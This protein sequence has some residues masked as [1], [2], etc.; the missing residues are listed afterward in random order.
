MRQLSSYS[1][2]PVDAVA[3]AGQTISTAS[4][5]KVS[6]LAQNGSTSPFS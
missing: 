5:V 2:F 1:D 6:V 3:L 4:S